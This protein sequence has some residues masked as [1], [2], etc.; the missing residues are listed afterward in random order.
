MYLGCELIYNPP[1]VILLLIGVV[2]PELLYNSIELR[3]EEVVGEWKHPG[4][5]GEFKKMS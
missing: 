5:V 4:L 2:I 1:S 3:E